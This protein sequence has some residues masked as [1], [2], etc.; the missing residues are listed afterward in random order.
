M[1]WRAPIF[2]SVVHSKHVACL[3]FSVLCRG[4]RGAQASQLSLYRRDPLQLFGGDFPFCWLTL[5]DSSSAMPSRPNSPYAG[6]IRRGT[7]GRRSRG[8]P[9][10]PMSYGERTSLPFFREGKPRREPAPQ[11]S[12]IF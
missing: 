1:R 9:R 4:H 5:V 2:L 6:A 7:A 10:T 11:P 3:P 8:E 12:S